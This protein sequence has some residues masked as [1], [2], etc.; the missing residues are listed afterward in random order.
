MVYQGLNQYLQIMTI[1]KSTALLV[2]LLI[3]AACNN[4]QKTGNVHSHNAI[5][6][7]YTGYSETIEA[8]ADVQPLAVG[9]SSEIT[10]HFT[11]LETFK[12]I[13]AEQVTTALVVGKKGL[14]QVNNQSIKK[15][16]YKFILQPGTA[17]LGRLEFTLKVNEQ[18]QVI[19]IPGIEVYADAH[20]AAHIAEKLIPT[21]PN[22]ISFT[23]EQS[24]KVNF[25]TDWPQNKPFGNVIK[26]T[27]K[28]DV[29]P[30]DKYMITAK[31]SGFVQFTSGLI[32]QGKAVK[33]NECLLTISGDGL[34]ENNSVVRLK[35]AKEEFDIAKANYNRDK[36]LFEQK[37]VSERQLLESKARYNNA[38]TQWNNLN[39]TVDQSGEKVL[40]TTGGFIHDVLVQNGEFVEVGAPLLTV[41]NH[42][43]MVLKAM[44]RQVHRTNLEW[45]YDATI[46]LN[47]GDVISLDKLNGKIVSVAQSLNNDNYLI[48]VTIEVDYEQNL[49]SGGFVNVYLKT[50]S[51]QAVVIVPETALTETQGLYFVYIQLTPELFERRQVRVGATD[52]QNRVITSGLNATERLV[53]QGATLVKLA[54]VSNTIDPHAGHVH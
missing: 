53:S 36:H 26:A 22:A 44:V 49:V 54:A 45:L 34:T 31:S 27:A 39:N 51:K 8:F 33:N 11:D 10:V 2:V 7:P 6:V 52:G 16:I 50:K 15:G 29:S 1:Y 17:G 19:T 43:R 46:E 23:K 35:K 48:P 41:I 5:T 47:N 18:E 9:V 4:S 13:E 20:D 30:L 32:S 42:K 38:K 12:P 14:R 21:S 3:Y 25:K 37:I 24:W 40:A 28:V